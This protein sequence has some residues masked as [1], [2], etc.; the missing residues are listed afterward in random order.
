MFVFSEEKT[1][2]HQSSRQ[3][4]PP[5]VALCGRVRSRSTPETRP[6]TASH[7][8][9]G[10]RPLGPV[11]GCDSSLWDGGNTGPPA[12]PRKTEASEREARPGPGLESNKQSE[13]QSAQLPSCSNETNVCVY[14]S[15]R[16]SP[17]KYTRCMKR[18]RNLFM[19]CRKHNKRPETSRWFCVRFHFSIL[20]KEKKI[21]LGW[22]GDL[23]TRHVTAKLCVCESGWRRCWT[24][25]A[26]DGKGCSAAEIR[27]LGL[28]GS[29]QF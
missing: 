2:F 25:S 14:V 23:F 17:S 7:P 26:E 10:P 5:A 29:A 9:S 19:K 16:D 4:G 18:I 12:S 11:Q 13:P 1:H 27:S 6:R 8:P 20:W 21:P 22:T 3:P 24:P 28:N 15:C